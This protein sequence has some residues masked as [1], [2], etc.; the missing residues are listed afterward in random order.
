MIPTAEEL[1]RYYKN[2]YILLEDR[3]FGKKFDIIRCVSTRP[4]WTTIIKANGE[5][6]SFAADI[7]WGLKEG[8]FVP[9][10]HTVYAQLHVDAALKH[11]K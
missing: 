6:H 1:N 8:W 11:I 5:K 10:S 7:E 3:L 2:Y 4:S 9:F